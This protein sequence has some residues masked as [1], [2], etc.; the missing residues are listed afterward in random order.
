MQSDAEYLAW[1]V[2]EIQVLANAVNAN[3]DA[4]SGGFVL[5]ATVDL[6]RERRER[7]GR[8]TGNIE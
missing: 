5:Q 8:L 4:R 3:L 7:L 6:L 2:Y 1:L